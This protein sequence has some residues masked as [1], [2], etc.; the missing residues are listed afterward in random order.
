MKTA[1]RLLP[2]LLSIALALF[3]A[4][5]ATAGPVPGSVSGVVFRDMDGDGTRDAGEPGVANRRVTVVLGDTVI[6]TDAS[7]GT[8]AFIVS[9]LPPG[10]YTLEVSLNAG[11]GLCGDGAASFDP[12][13]HSFCV[14]V[15]FPWR[16][17]AELGPVT[18]QSGADTT[19]DIGAREE[20]VAVVTGAAILE[21]DYAPAGTPIEALVDGLE[22]GTTI[23]AG[24]AELFELHILGESE[25]AGCATPGATVALRVGGVPAG[26]TYAFEPFGSQEGVQFDIAHLSALAEHAWY[27]VEGTTATLPPGA[28]VRAVVDGAV[29]GETTIST[30]PPLF[31]FAVEPDIAGFSKLIVPSDTVQPGCGTPGA[32]V[33][34]L[35]NGV[36]N[37]AGVTWQP[38]VQRIDL[39]VQQIP[40]PTPEVE[41]PVLGAA[42]A[43]SE[44]WL[45]RW[46][47]MAIFGAAAVAGGA[48]ALLKRR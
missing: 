41:L 4:P 11:G 6:G 5:S 8:G 43:S 7:D 48:L 36:E 13:P 25:R 44:A 32:T 19:V 47:L 35:V 2:P 38:G 18:V 30:D 27:W 29:C 17:T 37:E 15:T 42:G 39:A 9:N 21:D 16:A 10:D 34:F 3:G 28:T 14:N 23:A 33:T 12:F 26:E 1:T 40:T 46:P 22:C 20:D 24:G 45:I 31:G